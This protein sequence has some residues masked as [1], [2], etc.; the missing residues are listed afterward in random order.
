MR[1]NLGRVKTFT[2]QEPENIAARTIYETDLDRR[3]WW[4]AAR[5]MQMERAAACCKASLG[6]GGGGAQTFMHL[7]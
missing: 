2:G 3:H 6:G 7:H 1:L 4:N 5:V